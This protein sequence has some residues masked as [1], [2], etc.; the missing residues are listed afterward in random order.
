MMQGIIMKYFTADQEVEPENE[1]TSGIG[2]T[3][4]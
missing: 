4:K 3:G 1:R 2:S